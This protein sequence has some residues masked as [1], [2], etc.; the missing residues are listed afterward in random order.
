LIHALGIKLRKNVKILKKSVLVKN[1]VNQQESFCLMERQD[2]LVRAQLCSDNA[3][4]AFGLAS[5]KIAEIPS[6]SVL[7]TYA[8]IQFIF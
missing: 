1:V 7:E 5:S 2:A 6:E 3:M 8:A 4:N